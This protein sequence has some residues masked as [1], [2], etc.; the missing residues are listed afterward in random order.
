MWQWNSVH[1]E[2][3]QLLCHRGS[4]CSVESVRCRL[5]RNPSL[6]ADLV[7]TIQY[8]K[9][10]LTKIRPHSMS[11]RIPAG[12]HQINSRCRLTESTSKRRANH[13][14][15]YDCHIIDAVQGCRRREGPSIAAKQML[16]DRLPH[17]PAVD[18]PV[19]HYTPSLLPQDCS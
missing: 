6:Q 8:N 9:I 4:A 13:A 7:M 11:R 3:L 16:S 14:S 5:C 19:S 17:R 1:Y 12:S 10:S 18:W 15:P 2:H